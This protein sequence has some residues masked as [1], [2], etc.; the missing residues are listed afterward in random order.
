[1]Q[2]TWMIVGVVLMAVLVGAAVP[3]LFQLF[4][5]L[6]ATRGLLQR[7]GPKLEG[8]LTE[9]RETSQR[10][11]RIGSELESSARRAKLL[12][13]LAG[14]LGEAMRGLR[15]SLRVASALTGALG[16]A[17]AAAVRALTELASA[18]GTREESPPGEAEGP[19]ESGADEA[20]AAGRPL[21]RGE[22]T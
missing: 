14:D 12:L 6:R 18:E 9:V 16:P 4:A 22:A 19:P 2:E 5:T 3:V 8:T 1:M 11:N 13:D 20:G 15:E 7:L 17:I 10:L 21:E